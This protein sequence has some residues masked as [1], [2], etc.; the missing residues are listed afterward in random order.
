LSSNSKRN[1]TGPDGLRCCDVKEIPST[2]E[3]GRP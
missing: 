2:H 1:T 3:C